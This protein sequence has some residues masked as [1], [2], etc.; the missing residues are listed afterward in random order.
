MVKMRLVSRGG[1]ACLNQ[2]KLPV[3]VMAEERRITQ[4]DGSERVIWMVDGDFI[5]S[6]LVGSANPFAGELFAFYPGE[7][8]PL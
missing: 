8:I 4:S 7:V 6:I 2:H 3:T 1:Y 5:P